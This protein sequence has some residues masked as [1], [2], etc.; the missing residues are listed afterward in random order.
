MSFNP[1]NR[2]ALIKGVKTPKSINTVY[3]V[4]LTEVVMMPAE[5][6]CIG[7]D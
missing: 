4:R 3:V 7:F 5:F 6:R 2:Y 1:M